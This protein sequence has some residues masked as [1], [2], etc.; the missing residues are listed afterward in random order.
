[1]ARIELPEGF[2]GLSTE[3]RETIIE[4]NYIAQSALCGCGNPA[5][6]VLV[7][8]HC[9]RVG[10]SPIDFG[11]DWH[12]I[13]TKTGGKVSMQASAMLAR[14]VERG[15]QYRVLERSPEAAAVEITTGAGTQTFRLTHEQVSMESYYRDRDGKIREKYATPASRVQMLWARVIS[16][17][18]RTMDPG[19]NRGVCTPEEVSDFAGDEVPQQEQ[20]PRPQQQQQQ[21][22]VEA[23]SA[24]VAAATQ[25]L[26]ADVVIRNEPAKASPVPQKEEPA[27]PVATAADEPAATDETSLS[28]SAL[29]LVQRLKADLNPKPEG[30]VKVCVNRGLSLSPSGEPDLEA[31]TPEQLQEVADALQAA[32]DKREEARKAQ[33]VETWASGLTPA[34]KAT[35]PAGKA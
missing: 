26:G 2:A 12:I 21:R 14:L 30:W 18:V 25:T 34:P 22:Q 24:P 16:D 35:A 27:A 6:G 11:Q 13:N 4:G 19:V 23:K 9:R 31:A 29:E 17:A 28:E 32:L 5:Q 3:M 33:S 7:A 15:G 20:Q 8:M 10:C 1:M